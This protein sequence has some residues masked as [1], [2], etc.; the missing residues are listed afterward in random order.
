[1]RSLSLVRNILV[2]RT[3]SILYHGINERQCIFQGIG[4][5]IYLAILFGKSIYTLLIWSRVPLLPSKLRKKIQNSIAG[6]HNTNLNFFQR[7]LTSI[8]SNEFRPDFCFGQSHKRY[9]FHV[10]KAPRFSDQ[11][12]FL[13]IFRIADFFNFLCNQ[14]EFEHLP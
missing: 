13:G 9:I 11:I 12:L 14:S 8:L 2:D 6:S 1:M 7:N 10:L 3:L 5:Y 4:V